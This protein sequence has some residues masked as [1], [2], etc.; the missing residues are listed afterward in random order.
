MPLRFYISNLTIK[1]RGNKELKAR[2]GIGEKKLKAQS[3]K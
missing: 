3:W 1:S 2:I